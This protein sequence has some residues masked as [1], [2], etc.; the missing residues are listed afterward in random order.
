MNLRALQEDLDNDPYEQAI[1]RAMQ[2]DYIRTKRKEKIHSI[3]HQY[4]GEVNERRFYNYIDYLYEKCGCIQ[5]FKWT[6]YHEKGEID[7]EI[8]LKDLETIFFDVVGTH[9]RNG[10]VALNCKHKDF[11]AKLKA[12]GSHRGY[13]AF[14][15]NGEWRFLQVS[16]HLPKGDICMSKGRNKHVK[17]PGY[18]FNYEGIPGNTPESS[19]NLLNEFGRNHVNMD[20]SQVI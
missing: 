1:I 16:R 17:K 4:N 6:S 13:L 5:Y 2:K 7:F 11:K 9:D 10:H 20:V 12:F 3:A 8:Q 14:E 15:L 18:V 19:K